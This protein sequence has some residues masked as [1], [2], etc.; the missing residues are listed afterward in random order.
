MS[1]PPF[2]VK[3]IFTMWISFIAVCIS[4]CNAQQ[5]YTAAT[6]TP[7]T[8]P[9]VFIPTPFDD[10][11]YIASVARRNVESLSDDEIVKLLV[12]QWLEGYKMNVSSQDA[13][14]DYEVSEVVIQPHLPDTF[15]AIVKFAILPSKVPNNWISLP[16]EVIENDLWWHLSGAFR[17]TK[18]GEYF[19]LRTSFRHYGP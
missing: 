4:G 1:Q 8:S 5:D 7:S 11:E 18:E 13:I 2:H 10:G 15:L 14:L 6:T 16:V 19:K 3:M 12:G 9:I 17:V